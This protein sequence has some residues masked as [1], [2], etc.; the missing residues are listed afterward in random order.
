MS[1]MKKVGGKNMVQ[2]AD[3]KN[4]G[5]YN[6]RSRICFKYSRTEKEINSDPYFHSI[7]GSLIF[8]ISSYCWK[9]KMKQF[10]SGKSLLTRPLKFVEI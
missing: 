10:Q 2:L 5:F 4:C 7:D 1:R 9:R 6:N 3:C 8:R